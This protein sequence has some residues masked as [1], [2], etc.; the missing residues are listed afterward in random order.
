MTGF[1]AAGSAPIV[2]GH[3]IDNPETIATAIRIGNPASWKQAVAAADDSGGSISKVTDEEI[4]S[5][6]QLLADRE[7][8]FCEPASAASVAGVIRKGRQGLFGDGQIVVCILTGHG[9]KD[10]DRALASVEKPK[11]VP[12]DITAVVREIGL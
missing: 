8:I 4:L 9:L 3:P 10:P 2:D 1:Q 11:K 12:N 6:Y 7:G 5:A